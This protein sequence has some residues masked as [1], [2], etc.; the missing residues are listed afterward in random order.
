MILTKE[1]GPVKN[2]TTV[3]EIKAT[4]QSAIHAAAGEFN[5]LPRLAFKIA[6]T[7]THTPAINIIIE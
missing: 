3:L 6:K 7:G 5:S 1:G 2:K 4:T